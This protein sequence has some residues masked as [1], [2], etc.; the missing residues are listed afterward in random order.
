MG[1]KDLAAAISGE[2]EFLHNFGLFGLGYRGA[3]EVGA[4][5]VGIAL[6]FLQALLVMEPFVTEE[7]A[8]IHA[9]DGNDHCTYL[10]RWF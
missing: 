1:Q 7:L 5:S 8:A 2:S 3:V 9:T 10:W 6:E 4:L